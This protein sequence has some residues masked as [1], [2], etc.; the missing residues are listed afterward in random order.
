MAD[1]YFL[2]SPAAVDATAFANFVTTLGG[3]ADPDNAIA[4]RISI[5]NRH[6]W[7]FLS[8][9]AL[10]EIPDDIVA[11]LEDRLGARPRTCVTLEI[12]RRQGSD[13]VAI[14]FSIKFAEHWPAVLSDLEDGFFEIADLRRLQAART[15]LP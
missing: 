13:S 4:W 12:S 5:D 2:L 8:E 15:G 10:A 6:V 3:V 14:A 1:A 7:I 9:Q 11:K